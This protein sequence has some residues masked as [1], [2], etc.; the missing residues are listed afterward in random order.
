M[1]I[2]E[3]TAAV[4]FSGFMLFNLACS[5][6]QGIEVGSEYEMEPEDFEDAVLDDEDSEAAE[7]AAEEPGEGAE[8]DGPPDEEICCEVM[9]AGDGDEPD[10][11]YTRM[12]RQGCVETGNTVADADAC[13]EEAPEE[14]AP[15]PP[16]R[17]RPGRRVTK[18]KGR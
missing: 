18:P 2:F 11:E 16:S 13:G 7:D 5:G 3:W 8:N 15:S 12:T 4:C 10:T 14:A 6:G 1:R 17:T 9:E